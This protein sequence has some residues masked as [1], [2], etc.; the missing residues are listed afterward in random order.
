[1]KKLTIS[2]TIKEVT[3]VELDALAIDNQIELPE[4]YVSFM[5]DYGGT[6]L[7][8]NLY[9]GR[10]DINF[11]LPIDSK[12]N[13]CVRLILEAYTKEVHT[14]Y[15]LPF[16]IDSGGW[17]FCYSTAPDSMGHIYIDKFGSGEDPQHVFLEVSLDAFIAKFAE[18][19]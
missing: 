16:A 19:E 7:L 4:E 17:V 12:R 14:K 15:W 2:D 6:E 1:M 18:Q 3:K 8:E 5:V 9:D 10:H 11:V 13:A